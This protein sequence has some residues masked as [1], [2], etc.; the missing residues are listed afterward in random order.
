MLSLSGSHVSHL[1]DFPYLLFY[2]ICLLAFLLC[3]YE[4]SLTLHFTIF[5]EF[6]IRASLTFLFNCIYSFA[7]CPYLSEE[8]EIDYVCV[9]GFLVLLH[10][11]LFR[12]DFIFFLFIL[13]VVFNAEDF[14]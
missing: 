12:P 7:I 3:Y 10:F 6:L 14:P 9:Y 2:Y 8:I 4:M 5:I 13:V 1:F 11:F